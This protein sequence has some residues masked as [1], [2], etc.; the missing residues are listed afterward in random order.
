MPLEKEKDTPRATTGKDPRQDLRDFITSAYGSQ[1]AFA[2]ALG[3]DS[4]AL[5][6]VILG[7]VP[8]EG[9]ALEDWISLLQDKLPLLDRLTLLWVLDYCKNNPVEAKTRAPVTSSVYRKPLQCSCARDIKGE[10]FIAVTATSTNKRL[11]SIY[12]G[13]CLPPNT[14]AMKLKGKELTFLKSIL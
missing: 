12:C 7:R 5:S 13:E 4:G 11:V 8:C 1:K 6:D 3:C 10:I 2:Q 14:F 9:D